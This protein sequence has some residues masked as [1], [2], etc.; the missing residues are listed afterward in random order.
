MKEKLKSLTFKVDLNP[1]FSQV[2]NS[3]FVLG[4]A[5][6]AYAGK[7]RNYSEIPTEAFEK[8]AESLK[9]VP[10][11]GNWIPND[12]EMEGRFGGH[13]VVL[14]SKG[15]SIEY[16]RKPMPYGVVPENNNPDW[17]EVKDEYGN[18][19]L[20]YSTDVILWEERYPAQINAI[21]NGY[22]AQ[23]ME[24]TV[25]D[26]YWDEATDYF[27]IEDFRYDALCLLGRNN[28]DASKNVEPCFEES[29]VTTYSFN[30]EKEEFK[31]QF[32]MLLDELKNTYLAKNEG[33]ET[34]MENKDKD[35]DET[36][37]TPDEKVEEPE[38]KVEDQDFEDKDDKK[39]E[40]SEDLDKDKEECEEDDESGDKEDKE[41]SEKDDEDDY[42]VLDLAYSILK[43]AYHKL[44][45]RLSEVESEKEKYKQYHDN[46]VS[47]E[48]EA[49]KNELL[50]KFESVIGDT[51]EYSEIKDNK[52]QLTPEEIQTKLSV[53]FA[54]YNL[55]NSK[56]KKKKD[57]S[58][59]IKV[60]SK[61][62]KLDND[63]YGGL[64]IKK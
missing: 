34:D 20:Y 11:V 64:F 47:E 54:N 13:D 63:P 51:D 26:G 58:T 29:E 21:R 39:E 8:A 41:E 53:A 4:R 23:S 36:V 49:A 46:K 22:A 35:F 48:E 14:E 37:E 33:G 3:G 52:D 42:S 30:I 61:N 15:N 55:S 9:L 31:A 38:E 1:N 5:R 40:K 18:T 19:T 57:D 10:V 28:E 59:K 62:F 44:E 16:E 12:S 7:N 17:E 24:I 43:E 2:K 50:E 27:V 32:T 25:N 45:N 60:E 6:I 56:N